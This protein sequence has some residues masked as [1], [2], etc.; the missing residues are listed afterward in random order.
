MLREAPCPELDGVWAQWG[1]DC[2][3]PICYCGFIEVC[4]WGGGE[5]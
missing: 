4:A 3:Q 5:T 2:F 1:R